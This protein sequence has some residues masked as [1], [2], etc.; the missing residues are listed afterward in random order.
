[1]LRHPL[2]TSGPKRSA[3]ANR[4]LGFGRTL[5]EDEAITNISFIFAAS[6]SFWKRSELFTLLRPL[7]GWKGGSSGTGS[8]GSLFELEM[9]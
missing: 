4:G 2:N 5:G 6:G 3:Q 7:G 1:M 9:L 8:V